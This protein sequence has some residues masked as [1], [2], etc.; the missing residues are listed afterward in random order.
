MR[1]K[2]LH[3]DQSLLL[4][5]IRS[6]ETEP[7]IPE[8]SSPLRFHFKH[9]ICDQG[10]SFEGKGVYFYFQMYVETVLMSRTHGAQEMPPCPPRA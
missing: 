6:E 3:V 4:L 1:R 2:G 8:E 5:H 10:K 9:Q 7:E